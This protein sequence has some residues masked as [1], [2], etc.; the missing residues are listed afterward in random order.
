MNG[1]DVMDSYMLL[2]ANYHAGPSSREFLSVHDPPAEFRR[3]YLRASQVPRIVIP[4]I[5]KKRRKTL[6]RLPAER[7]RFIEIFKRNYAT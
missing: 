1:K 7:Q 4:R 2:S 3:S 6:G 5:R